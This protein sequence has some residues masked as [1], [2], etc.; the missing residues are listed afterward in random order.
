MRQAVIDVRDVSKAFEIPSHRIDSLKERSVHPFA[1]GAYRRLEALRS[2]SFEV[3]Q[4]EF[5]GILGRNGSGKSTLLKILSSIYRADS[6]SIRMAGRPAPFIELGVGF[7]PE[8]SARDNVVIN[9]VMMGL[10]QRE[11][12][13]KLDTVL[14]FAELEEF[15]DLKLKNYSSG[16]LVRLAFS[17]M[18]QS[19]AEILLIDEVLAVGDAAFQQ[20]CHEVF[21]EIRESNRTVVLVTHD[22][23]SVQTHCHR[24]MLLDEGAVRFIGDPEEAARQYLVANFEGSRLTSNEAKHFAALT[25]KGMVDEDSEV[26]LIP[27]LLVSLQE[28]RLEGADGE[29]QS[30]LKPGERIRVR[31]IVE[32]RR[33]LVNPRFRIH[34]TQADGHPLFAIR[35]LPSEEE[36]AIVPT[37]RSI[38]LLAS[39]DNPLLD[40]RYT[41][42]CWVTMPRS[43]H[44]VAQQVTRL[45]ELT[46][47]GGAV[48]EGI[49]SVEGDLHVDFD[50]DRKREP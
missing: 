18:I 1:R 50:A 13:R 41:V 36:N 34:V 29:L 47:K 37:G 23:T 44:E 11:A 30:S 10:S 39:L 24:G 19:D 17:L 21:R 38:E 20:K 16:M 5:F 43:E 33:E 4:G 48:A 22:M 45:V 28:A 2:V 27:D 40:G 7:N 3:G 42:V 26:D 9:G 8:L 35:H 25:P 6:G 15:A 46:V 32:A 31:A 12:R 14:E 49:M